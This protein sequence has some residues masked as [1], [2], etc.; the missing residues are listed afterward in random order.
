M[1][2]A[3]D[4][5]AP[6]LAEAIRTASN[7]NGRNFGLLSR[8]VAGTIGATLVV[9]APGS[10]GGAVEAFDAIEPVAGPGGSEVLMWAALMGAMNDGPGKTLFYEAVMPWMGGVTVF[11]YDT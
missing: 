3:I 9:N 6:G 5:E 11:S 10:P 2:A 8:A 7:A 1:R 4:R